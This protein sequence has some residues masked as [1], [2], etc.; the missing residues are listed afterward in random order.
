MEFFGEIDK[1][2][3][4]MIQSEYP[5]WYFDSQIVMLKEEIGSSERALEMGRIPP[6]NVPYARA[7][8]QMMKEKLYRIK[9]SRPKLS[10]G[11]RDR[12]NR[13][14]KELSAKIGESLFDRSSMMFG[15]ASPNQEAKRMTES[16]ISLDE[17]LQELAI[18]CNVKVDDGKVSRNG[19][20]KVFKIIGK[21]L[22]ESTN[23]EVLRK[24]KATVRTNYST[25]L[26]EE[27]SDLRAKRAANLVKARAAK[28]AK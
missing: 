23:L 15:I 16:C 4:G 22:G 2:A 14:Y 28:K 21:L 5:A 24:D 9:D 25:Q 26:S 6:E 7:E 8:L 12:L 27:A 10:D 11:E 1:N 18:A 17:P 20:A 3:R 13:R 19:A